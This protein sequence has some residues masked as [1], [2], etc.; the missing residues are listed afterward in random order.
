MRR[1]PLFLKQCY[2][3]RALLW[4]SED[5]V[6]LSD[7]RVSQRRYGYDFF[8]DDEKKG[9]LMQLLSRILLLW[10]NVVIHLLS[11][12]LFLDC[13]RRL[14]NLEWNLSSFKYL[15]PDFVLDLVWFSRYVRHSL[16]NSFRQYRK[17]ELTDISVKD[18]LLLALGCFWRCLDLSRIRPD[19]NSNANFINW[20]LDRL[21]DSKRN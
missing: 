11:I 2:G 6:C 12:H 3:D 8:L 20:G 4:R 1:H 7:I 5:A 16:A 9:R 19:I 10:R 18:R 15:E 14:L 17:H 13:E 21:S